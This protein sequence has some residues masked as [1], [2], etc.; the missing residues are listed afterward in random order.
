M[1]VMGICSF[2]IFMVI[3]VFCLGTNP[4]KQDGEV[5]GLSVKILLLNGGEFYHLAMSREMISSTLALQN[6]GVRSA[7]DYAQ[8][9]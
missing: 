9:D 6:R 7:T 1:T 3:L 2:M 4:S 5:N 8:E